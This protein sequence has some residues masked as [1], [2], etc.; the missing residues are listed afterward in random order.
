MDISQI[1]LVRP[2]NKQVLFD[3]RPFVYHSDLFTTESCS[4]NYESVVLRNTRRRQVALIL[5]V[6][7][8]K[9]EIYV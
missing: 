7:T 3:N 8:A 5:A 1:F 9:Y 4:A 2:K 6:G